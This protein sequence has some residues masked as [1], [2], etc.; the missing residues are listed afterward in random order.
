MADIKAQGEF[1]CH[2]VGEGLFYTGEI[3]FWNRNTSFIFIYDCGSMSNSALE[4]PL[5]YFVYKVKRKGGEI[6]MLILSHLHQDHVSGVE[7]LCRSVKVKEVMLPY[8]TPIERLILALKYFNKYKASWYYEFLSDPVKFLLE[9]GVERVIIIGE[10][11][12]DEE[13][14]VPRE[15]SP[16]GPEET[17]KKKIRHKLYN[18][19]NQKNESLTMDEILREEPDWET[20]WKKNKLL[21]L[22]HQGYS[23]VLGLWVFRFFNYKISS[24]KIKNFKECVKKMFNKNHN[25]VSCKDDWIKK[26]I[27]GLDQD[28]IARLKECYHE[29]ISRYLNNTSL[30]VFHGPLGKYRIMPWDI[31]SFG[32]LLTGDINLN[33]PK[34]EEF[35]KHFKEYLSRI[36]FIL[37]PHHGARNNWNSRILMDCYNAR[38]WFASTGVKTPYGHPSYYVVHEIERR[39]NMFLW[40][41][42]DTGV[43]WRCSI[44]WNKKGGTK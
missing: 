21:L 20:F 42:E 7:F 36:I 2:P 11:P 5:E 33:L 24:E 30:A 4:K 25:A 9:R 12:P 17:P 8:L 22:S 27:L 31:D 41:N 40:V 1:I 29:S 3:E 39:K 23:I 13:T 32:F 28:K 38:V 37:V 19:P 15:I 34:Y 14:P 44:E 10:A 43:F 35:Q 18:L 6:D 26:I 16:F